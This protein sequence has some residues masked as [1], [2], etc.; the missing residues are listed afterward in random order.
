MLG[1]KY[2]MAITEQMI[3]YGQ[4]NSSL[5]QVA[6]SG[7]WVVFEVS[8]SPLIEP[9]DNDPAVLTGVAPKHWLEA[10]TPWYMDPTAW[11]VWPSSGG[12]KQWQ[13]ISEGETPTANPTTPVAVT[14]TQFGRDTI[15]FDVTKP[16]TPILVKVSY[17]P[18]WKVSGADGPWRVGPNL[19]VVVPTSESVTLSYGTSVIDW[20]S[21][22]VTFLGFVGIVLLWRAGPIVFP[23]LVPWRRSRPTPDSESES[24][25]DSAVPSDD[26]SVSGDADPR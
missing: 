23:E 9:L 15:S 14:N 5:K 26:V 6:Q 24:D 17:F 11:N 16:G 22:F 7:P 20:G 25:V 19:M 10:V 1:V 8:D 4:A 3:A 18:N 21:W 13:R 2:Y 12:P